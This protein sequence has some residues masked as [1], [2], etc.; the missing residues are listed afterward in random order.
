MRQEEDIEQLELIDGHALL[1]GEREHVNG[2]RDVV[3]GG[4]L[5]S[6]HAAA[7]TLVNDANLDLR[8]L[9]HECRALE[10]FEIG[11]EYL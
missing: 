7:T 1:D 2:H 8:V 6:H 10:V 4:E 9:A 5:R 11:I 3:F